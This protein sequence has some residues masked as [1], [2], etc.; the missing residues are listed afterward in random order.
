M[1]V[2]TGR[3]LLLLCREGVV[4]KGKQGGTWFSSR[5][6]PRRVLLEPFLPMGNPRSASLY[7]D[8]VVGGWGKQGIGS[9]ESRSLNM[10]RSVVEE[11]FLV[12]GN[13]LSVPLCREGVIGEYGRQ[14]IGSFSLLSLNRL[15]MV[16]DEPFLARD[17]RL[18]NELF[19]GNA[20]SGG[21]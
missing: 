6:I 16:V 2:L 19:F 7:R 14:G 18:A 15:R 12:I 11:P 8:G 4:G 21:G 17:R 13:P 1:D 20:L 9:F 5:N 3:E 10:L